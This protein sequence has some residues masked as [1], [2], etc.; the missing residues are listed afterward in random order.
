MNEP[1]TPTDQLEPPLVE[2]RQEAPGSRPDTRIT[3]LLLTQS[4]RS[5]PV[6]LA[7]AMVGGS[8]EVSTVMPP[9]LVGMLT[10]SALSVCRASTAPAG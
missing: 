4:A 9:K 1:P 10:L 6:S 5:P 7:R 2:Y 3:G 8:A